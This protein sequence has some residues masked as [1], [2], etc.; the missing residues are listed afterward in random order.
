MAPPPLVTPER[1]AGYGS[2]TGSSPGPGYPETTMRSEIESE[3]AGVPRLPAPAPHWRGRLLL[4]LAFTGG[5]ARLGVEFA[6]PPPLAPLFC[7]APFIL[8]TPICLVLIFLP[9][10][11]YPGR[12]LGA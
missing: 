12:P 8:G 9:I 3:L 11:S 7:Q 6:A 2:M 5:L 10:G 4:P 1:G